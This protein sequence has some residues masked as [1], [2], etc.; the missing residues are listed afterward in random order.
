LEDTKKIL[1]SATGTIFNRYFCKEVRTSKR[2]FKLAKEIRLKKTIKVEDFFG[3]NTYHYG[4]LEVKK[5]KASGGTRMIY[6]PHP[7]LK[8]L[9]GSIME[10]LLRFPAHDVAHGFVKG[11]S[12]YTCVKEILSAKKDHPHIMFFDVR[13]AFPSIHQEEISTTLIGLGIE[14]EVVKRIAFFC[15]HQNG[16]LPQGAPTSPHILNLVYKNL[17]EKLVE[18]C[19]ENGLVY[20]RYA[21]NFSFL[22]DTPYSKTDHLAKIMSITM[23]SGRR[24]HPPVVI[25]D[26]RQDIRIL[27]LNIITAQNRIE[28]PPDMK[29]RFRY[30]LYRA[31]CDAEYYDE[32][33]GVLANLMMIY[34]EIPTRFATQIQKHPLRKPVRR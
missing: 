24:V 23:N 11:R 25:D 10:Y 28:I 32:A 26:P 21:D 31:S 17:D 29:E 3:D 8:E 34:G 18:Y 14:E 33:R 15:T 4:Y 2:I 30:I 1:K 13:Q 5:K 12:Y 16:F 27:G 7:D 19:Q 6:A 9:Q 22:A 20:L